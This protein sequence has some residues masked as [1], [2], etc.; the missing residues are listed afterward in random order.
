MRFELFYIFS[1]FVMNSNFL[2][3]RRA[4]PCFLPFC[5]GFSRRTVSPPRESFTF[6]PSVNLS[7]T[8]ITSL[9]FEPTVTPESRQKNAPPELIF[10]RIV[11]SL[12]FFP[13]EIFPSTRTER[14]SSKRHSSRRLNLVLDWDFFFMAIFSNFLI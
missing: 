13:L 6:L 14:G 9:S 11:S 4:I 8:S 10:W 1:S 7:G 12:N 5:V 2:L 3:N